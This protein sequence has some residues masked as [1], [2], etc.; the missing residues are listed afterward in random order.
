MN[1]VEHHQIAT[2]GFEGDH[3]G[4]HRV[5]VADD[6]V[7]LGVA[8][9][10]VDLGGRLDGGV[11]QTEGRNGPVEVLDVPVGLAQRQLLT[12]GGLIDLDDLDTGGLEIEH[13]VADGEGEL[14]GLLLV[15]DVLARPGPV[16]DGHRA[17]EHALHHM[18][19]L[20]LGVRGPFHGNRVGAGNVAPDDRGLDATGAVGL[21]PSVLG[22]QEAVE[23]LAEIF[24]HVV[25]LEFAVDQ[26]VEADLL[27]LLDDGVNLGLDELVVGFLGDLALAQLGTL[28]ANLLGLG[29]GADSGGR[30]Q[31]Q[32]E[33]LAL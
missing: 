12:Q 9:V 4:I 30:Q 14:L 1:G 6:V 22:E 2:G 18:V 21:D 7:E 15:G 19:G 29:E 27:L 33:G 28:G 24:D 23:V 20:G 13:F 16:E 10:G 31:R 25:T 3:V 26:H 17:G 5:D 8:H 11:H 32:A